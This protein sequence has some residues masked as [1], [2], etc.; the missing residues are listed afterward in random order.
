[1]SRAPV[2]KTR[3]IYTHSVFNG[4]ETTLTL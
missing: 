4:P 3:F 2:H 1:V